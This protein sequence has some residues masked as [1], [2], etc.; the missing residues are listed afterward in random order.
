MGK[1]SR[2]YAP[3]PFQTWKL[4]IDTRNI[5]QTNFFNWLENNVRGECFYSVVTF[6][7]RTDPSK[8][9][10]NR[11]RKIKHG[12]TVIEVWF[13]RKQ[14]AALCRIWWPEI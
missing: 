8:I 9:Y 1:V 10:L 6:D 3:P 2:V 14:D 7:S 11:V 5:D 12:Y 13:K 4:S